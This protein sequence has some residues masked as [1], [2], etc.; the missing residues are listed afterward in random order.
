MEFALVEWRRQLLAEREDH[1]ADAP[2]RVL[3]LDFGRNVRQRCGTP[4][5]GYPSRADGPKSC[6]T[7]ASEYRAGGF[8]TPN[9][10]PGARYFVAEGQRHRPPAIRVRSWGSVAAGRGVPEQRSP[11][12]AGPPDLPTQLTAGA[13]QSLPLDQQRRTFVQ[14]RER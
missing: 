10:P 3:R 11:A 12:E 14:S 6:V 9:D 4:T 7:G 1:T 13:W 2:Y 8:G 5:D